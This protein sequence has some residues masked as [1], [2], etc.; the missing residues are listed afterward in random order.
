MPVSPSTRSTVRGRERDRGA[1]RAP[2]GDDLPARDEDEQPE[3]R[4]RR[5][6]SRA[7]ARGAAARRGRARA[8]IGHAAGSDLVSTAASL[9][10]R[11][12]SRRFSR[13]APYERIGDTARKTS[14]R[15]GKSPISGTHADPPN[16]TMRDVWD[17]LGPPQIRIPRSNSSS[18]TPTTGRARPRSRASW[19]SSWRCAASAGDFVVPAGRGAWR[20]LLA[21]N[22]LRPARVRIARAGLGLAI[23]SGLGRLVGERRTLT[24]RPGDR[25]LLDYLSTALGQPG[26]VFA[27]TDRPCREF[28]TPVLQLFTADGR[29]VGFA[30]IGW[31]PVTQRMIDD[32]ADALRRVR[33]AA[34]SARAG[35][36]GPVARLLAG[37]RGHGHRADADR[38]PSPPA[39][40]HGPR[41]PARGDRRGRRPVAPTP[42]GT[43]DYL[44]AATETGFAAATVG[45]RD[46]L[47]R[48]ERITADFGDARPHVRPLA[49][50]LGPVEPRP[51]AAASLFAWDWAYSA[52][53]V[54]LGFDALHFA[55]IPAEVLA[56]ASR[57]EAATHAAEVSEPALRALGPRR[58]PGPRR[59][60]APPPRARAAR[61]PRVAAAP[62]AAPS[63]RT[64]PDRHAREHD[65]RDRARHRAPSTCARSRAAAR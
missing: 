4:P 49:R 43:S 62:R 41:G 31:D 27:G 25:V 37:P 46:V 16:P 54:P 29:C 13:F 2:D 11:I 30:K 26:L 61:H 17:R 3:R 12:G 64:A 5:R 34:P 15:H 58:R 33:A 14:Q 22:R 59:R 20:P 36:R 7:A 39:A 47:H 21:Y 51:V 32:E 28:V 40:R 42:L 48:A 52:T 55:A 8:A 10:R 19:P 9:A 38:H 24:A 50:R 45:R 23:A 6:R 18:S 35:A 44:R 65:D 57:A 56:G 63:R 60:R 1:R 53:A